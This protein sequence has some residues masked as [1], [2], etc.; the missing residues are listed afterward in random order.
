M[1][2]CKN[3]LY[4]MTWKYLPISVRKVSKLKKP[5]VSY[6]G[7]YLVYVVDGEALESTCLYI[8][9]G[10]QSQEESIFVSAPQTQEG[11]RVVWNEAFISKK[12][13]LFS[14]GPNPFYDCLK[15][16]LEIGFNL[17]PLDSLLGNS[18]LNDI[19][20]I[21]LSVTSLYTLETQH[22]FLPFR[23]G[24]ASLPSPIVIRSCPFSDSNPN[25]FADFRSTGS[26][27]LTLESEGESFGYLSDVKYL[28]NMTG[29]VATSFEGTI[30][31]LVLGN[32]RKLNGDGDLTAIIA[33]D[34]I[35]RSV[36]TEHRFEQCLRAPTRLFAR[37]INCV[38][39]IYL[40]RN[41]KKLSWGTGVLLNE[42]TIVTNSH[43]L[44][45]FLSSESIT[46]SIVVDHRTIIDVT[47]KKDVKIPSNDI[48]LA[49]ISIE[50][51]QDTILSLKSTA[52]LGRISDVQYND[53]VQTVGFGLI[54]NINYLEPLICYGYL[55][56]VKETLAF[57]VRKKIPTMIVASASCWNGSSGGGLFSSSGKLLGII[58]SNAQVFKPTTYSVDRLETEKLPLFCLCL[59]IELVTMC[60]KMLQSNSIPRL[61]EEGR[62][63]WKLENALEDVYER[64]IKL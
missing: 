59:P 62:R 27:A 26:L 38:L 23:Y 1:E 29:G 51:Y 40:M 32:L 64:A 41:E 13:L 11:K 20:L 24:Q 14:K 48:D 22:L 8:N 19:E 4:R 61:L 30:I 12:C 10:G 60:F 63:L 57:E 31:G 17:F 39:P 25:L 9:H 33:W 54:K 56:A 52:I 35:F 55:S 6:S 15:Y 2:C 7:L 36:L 28:D 37:Q 58:C 50:R 43:V 42:S 53:I 46:C 49:F 5:L 47:S 45:P 18:I 3:R 44:A 16:A 21:Q 34:A